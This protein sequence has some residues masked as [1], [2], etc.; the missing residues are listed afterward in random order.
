MAVDEQLVTGETQIGQAVTAAVIRR[1]R[2]SSSLP[3]WM[4]EA[5][6]WL[7]ALK[8]L[9]LAVIA[10]IML[11]PFV[12]MVATSFSSAKDVIQGGLLL[13]PKHPT[14]DSYRALLDGGIVFRSLVI[15]ALL[16]VVGVA[17]QLAFTTALAYGLSKPDVPGSKFFLILVLGAFLFSPGMIPLYLLVKS[18]GLIDSYAS[19]ILPGLIGAWNLII[20]RSFFQGLPQDLFDAA[21]IDGANDLQILWRIVLPL[22]KAVLAVVGL[23][24]GV[25]IWN[26]FFSAILYINDSSKLPIQPILQQ[27]VLSGA[28]ITNASQFPPN[29]PPPPTQSLEMAMVVLATLPI[30]LVYPFVQKYFTKGVLTGAIKG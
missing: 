20:L 22:S 5:P 11:F 28:N 21:R 23:F 29:H 19:L 7:K 9:A 14:L 25:A 6:L 30:L 10:I 1:R 26:T 12:T 27:Y 3:P 18:L 16:T 24:T 4:E 15:T 17:V 8:F 2:R 13:F